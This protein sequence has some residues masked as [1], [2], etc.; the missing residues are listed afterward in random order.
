MCVWNKMSIWN[1][2]ILL[3]FSMHFFPELLFSKYINID[4]YITVIPILTNRNT[5]HLF[6]NFIFPLELGKQTNFNVT[7]KWTLCSF[8]WK[9]LALKSCFMLSLIVNEPEELLNALS[10]FILII[11]LIYR[12]CCFLSFLWHFCYYSFKIIFFN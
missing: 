4:F 9:N 11:L 8:F 1:N 7:E 5:M 10:F 2:L 12:L 6:A 3:L